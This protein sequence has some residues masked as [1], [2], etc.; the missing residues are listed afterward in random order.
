[1]QYQ[2]LI[3]ILQLTVDIATS[4][5]LYLENTFMSKSKGSSGPFRSAV[6]GQYVTPRQARANPRTTV[7]EA[8]GASGSTG[9]QYRSASSG[10]FVT[11]A[12]GQRNPRTTTHEK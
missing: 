9:G 8:P 10:R 2:L 3:A 5:A 1:M 7:H 4:A 11:P 12:H 6:T